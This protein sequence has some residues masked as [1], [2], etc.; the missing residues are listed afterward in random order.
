MEFRESTI[1]QKKISATDSREKEGIRNFRRKSNT[2]PAASINS[3]VKI[4]DELKIKHNSKSEP[5]ILN[6]VD[7]IFSTVPERVVTASYMKV[8]A[9]A[10]ANGS[11]N[12]SNLRNFD[13]D[14]KIYG[15]WWSLM[16]KLCWNSDDDM[17]CI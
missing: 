10:N 2:H 9:G 13:E 6:N 5:L 11:K 16:R 4:L 8:P 14:E 12:I 1:K 7:S 15:D 17:E 3:R